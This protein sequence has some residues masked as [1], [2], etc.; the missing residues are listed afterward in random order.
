M[1]DSYI[2]K[3]GAPPPVSP[4]KRKQRRSQIR[5]VA[6]TLLVIVV[7]GVG[8]GWYQYASSYAERAAA[9]VNAGILLLSPGHYPDAVDQFN[10][11]LEI[12]PN[13]ST[14]HFQRGVAEQTLGLLDRALADFADA[15][16]LNPRNTEARTASATVYRDK[17][18]PQRAIE[19]LTKV[20]AAKPDADAYY[21]RGTTFAG[22]GM[23][24]EAIKDFTQVVSVLG[25]A[26]WVLKSRAKSKLALGDEEGA[27]A[28]ETEAATSTHTADM[29]S[30]RY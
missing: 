28:D 12:D 1:Q 24:Q 2:I 21:Q 9:H 26:P 20:I 14:A 19:E 5:L 16:R 3:R 23:H 17:G 30:H 29:N 7:A 4:K 27:A 15:L 13:S 25:D 10:A 8:W 18:D 11:A 22:M 6:G